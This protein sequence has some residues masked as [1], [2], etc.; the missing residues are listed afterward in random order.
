[1]ALQGYLFARARDAQD[2]M[3]AVIPQ[4]LQQGFG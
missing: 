4:S 3:S 2:F 1:M